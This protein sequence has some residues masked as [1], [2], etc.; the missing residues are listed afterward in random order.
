MS[1]PPS[2]NP[3]V[4]EGFSGPRD[5]VELAK[6]V[7]SPNDEQGQWSKWVCVAIREKLIRDG[8]WPQGDGALRHELLALAEQIGFE[9]SLEVLRRKART[10]AKVSK[11]KHA[12]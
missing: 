6:K 5:L 8:N 9:P 10:A 2:S 7:A 4:K 12:A 1:R 3:A 11:L